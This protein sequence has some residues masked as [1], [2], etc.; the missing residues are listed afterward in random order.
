MRVC[1][2]SRKKRQA[3]GGGVGGVISFI[4]LHTLHLVGQFIVL[5]AAVYFVPRV[6]EANGSI[7]R[8]RSCHPSDGIISAKA[9][10][11]CRCRVFL[12]CLN[13]ISTR[14][15]IC[16]SFRLH[17]RAEFIE[18]NLQP[19]ERGTVWEIGACCHF[20]GFK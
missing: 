20:S 7:C 18:L 14:A 1:N 16:F 17:H 15:K 2:P 8:T 11:C 6:L 19:S 4:A 5:H 12:K 13:E 10:T 3:G 9:N